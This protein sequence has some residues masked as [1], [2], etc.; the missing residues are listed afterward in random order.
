MWPARPMRFALTPGAVRLIAACV[1]GLIACRAVPLGPP[2]ATISPPTPTS[3]P[4]LAPTATTATGPTPL[5]ADAAALQ[6]V[7]ASLQQ[8]VLDRDRAAYW[9]YVDETDAVFALEHARWAD[10]WSRAPLLADY[11]LKLDAVSF[12]G[13]TAT[14]TLTV[15]W[16]TLA[17]DETR[18]ASFPVRF[19]RA[20][21]GRWRYA[22]ELWIDVEAEH[23]LVRAQPG[24]AS[25]AETVR[26]A[27]PAVHAHVTRSLE[28]TPAGRLQI[29][30]YGTVEALV[31]NTLLS[32]PPIHGWNEPGEALKLY[33]GPGAAPDA[34]LAH[35]FTHF[36]EFDQAGTAR[37]RMPWWLSEGLAVYVAQDYAPDPA[38]AAQIDLV[39]TW[40]AE[41]DLA[42]WDTL[43]VFET[44]PPELWR[45]VY[46]QGYAFA[47]F[48][49]DTYGEPQ[50]NAWVRAMATDMD[51]AQA[52]P[53][54][55]GL[56]FEALDQQFRAWLAARPQP[57]PPSP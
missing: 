28:Y 8:A 36:I 9:A 5:A 56:T 7:V 3:A 47:T 53:A 29:K 43:S 15:S 35:E 44:T 38:Q 27:L 57:S 20:A 19:T 17:E 30:L 42:A 21:S 14:G 1:L 55:L 11:A 2:A 4:T 24:L 18:L 22:G 39:A 13:D 23:F 6:A 51:L 32:L 12:S 49:T 40:S 41:G 31:A 54:V 37:S 10:D 52:T 33:A 34:I 26:A 46:P 45:F 48:V 25:A 16:R 50:R